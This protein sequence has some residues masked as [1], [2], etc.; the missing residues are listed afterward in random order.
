M[1]LVV[2]SALRAG[3]HGDIRHQYRNFIAGLYGYEF[4]LTTKFR[5]NPIYEPELRCV[6]FTLEKFP[7]GCCRT[8]QCDLSFPCRFVCN[9]DAECVHN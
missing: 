7:K 1:E 8:S 9:T 3:L 5:L 2:G 6:P 4:F